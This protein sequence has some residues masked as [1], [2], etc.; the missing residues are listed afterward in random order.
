[1]GIYKISDSDKYQ[2]KLDLA[3][4]LITTLLEHEKN[5]SELI[6]RLEKMLK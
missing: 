3:D 4:L 1:V 2:K 6:D 5:L